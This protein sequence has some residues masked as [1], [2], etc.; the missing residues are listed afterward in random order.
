MLKGTKCQE[1]IKKDKQME[2]IPYSW[3]G[4]LKLVKMAILPEL[5]YRFNTI[6]IKFR[7]DFFFFLQKMIS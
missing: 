5:I 1:K 7:D 6:P 3:I 2:D 4:R